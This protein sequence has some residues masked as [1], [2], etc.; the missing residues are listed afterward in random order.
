MNEQQTNSTPLKKII[1]GK[2]FITVSLLL[3]VSAVWAN[4]SPRSSLIDHKSEPEQKEQSQKSKQQVLGQR[5]PQLFIKG[6]NEGYGSGGMIALA[7]TDEPAVSIGSYDVSGKVDVSLYEA[8]ERS[9]LEYLTHN[10]DGN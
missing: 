3:V 7:S 8:D 4:F 6:G 5:T 9:L 10:K 2:Y 1:T